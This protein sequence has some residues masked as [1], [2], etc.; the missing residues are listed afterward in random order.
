MQTPYNYYDM[1]K[2]TRDA[3][4]A[5]IHAACKALIQM[6]HPE[7][8]AGREDEAIQ[9]AQMLRDACDTLTNP[10]TRSSYDHWLE[11]QFG[12][13]ANVESESKVPSSKPMP[14][15]TFVAW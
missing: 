4:A 1:L 12:H 10:L 14:K 3:P 11:E 6:N 13:M 8:F 5:V 9:I 2:V 7:K 15:A